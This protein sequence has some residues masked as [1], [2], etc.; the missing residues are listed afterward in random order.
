MSTLLLTSQV[1]KDRF[2]HQITEHFDGEVEIIT[3]SQDNAS[4]C[5]VAWLST[6]LF[7][8]PEKGP[9]IEALRS[10][11][12]LR[13]LQSAAAGADLPFFT[14]LIARGVRISPSHANAISI[15]E[16]VI[17][18]VLAVFQDSRSWV[19]AQK[20]KRWAHHDFDEI[21]AT[22]WMIFGFGAIGT[23][24]AA[25]ANAF[26]AKVIGVRRSGGHHPLASVLLTPTSAL[27]QLPLADVVVLSR[28][29]NVDGKP[30]VDDAFISAMKPGSTLVNVGR[31][32]LVSLDAL[33]R[34]LERTQPRCAIVDVFDPE[35]LEP[36]SPLWS[37]PKVVITPH[38]S[39]GG[40]GRY[41]RNLETLLFNLS[42]Y[43]EG[44]PL[45]DEIVA[46]D[47]LQKPAT[48]A[49]FK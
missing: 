3:P 13:W 15:A 23:G 43:R 18:Q 35:P 45:K 41:Q 31:G 33:I 46:A 4:H 44:R 28:P 49:Q 14:E 24:V 32:S 20:E 26:G 42:A 6:D 22:T 19:E 36:E 48:P 30:L 39:A 34:G 16:Y 10:S 25:R 27:T 38:S 1:A 21:A 2:A 37:H 29:G 47:L 17:G 40:R 5:E 7:Y 11:S 12:T 8:S 9:F